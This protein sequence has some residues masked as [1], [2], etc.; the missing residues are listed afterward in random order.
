[1]TARERVT[2][3]LWV[4]TIKTI[5]EHLVTIGPDAMSLKDVELQLRVLAR[6]MQ[7]ANRKQVSL[8]RRRKAGRYHA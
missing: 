5:A 1:M 7:L 2:V 8:G 4:K 3:R 6:W